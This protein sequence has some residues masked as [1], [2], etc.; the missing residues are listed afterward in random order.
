MFIRHLRK[1]LFCFTVLLF[2][3][4]AI[5]ASDLD[6]SV[7]VRMP[8]RKIISVPFEKYVLGVLLSEIPS[9][10][11]LE[12]LKAQA[13]AIRSYTRA[14]IQRRQNRPY[15]VESSVMDQVYDLERQKR[16]P[17]SAYLKFKQATDETRNW[18]LYEKGQALKAFYHSDCGGH[19]TSS[20]NVWGEKQK[21]KGV[22]DRFCPSNPRASWQ[23]RF[24]Q[25]ELQKTLQSHFKLGPLVALKDIKILSHDLSGRAN[26][27]VIYF[28]FGLSRKISGQK[29][30]SLLG[31]Q[32]MRSTLVKLK[33][34]D[35]FYQF[36]GHGFGHGV[37]LCQWG[38]RRL[39]EK[40]WGFTQILKHYYSRI[41]L[42]NVKE[43]L[44]ANS[45]HVRD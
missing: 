31:F 24:H 43:T 22:K 7:K 4:I 29:L 11:P 42:K 18:L 8:D 27:F 32:K 37:G 14:V 33:K 13:V 17:A 12:A 25:D 30:R 34:I 1:F 44:L 39:A 6:Q 21:S 19:T 35:G 41:E 16:V 23:T 26:E 40:G 36:K 10:W 5:E 28:D 38:S 9:S 3:N 20:M 2:C 15:H 45:N